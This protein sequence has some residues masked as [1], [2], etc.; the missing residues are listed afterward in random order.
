MLTAALTTILVALMAVMAARRKYRRYLRGNIDISKALGTL[1]TKTAIVDTSLDLV[2]NAT[3]VSSVKATYSMSNWTP[4]AAA[5]PIEL[6]WA[7]GD[8]TL[9]EIEEW[10]ENAGS[11]N[12]GDLIAREQSRRKIRRIGTLPTDNALAAENTEMADGRLV[13]T[14]I[15]FAL[16]EG[17]QLVLVAYNNGGASV[18]TSDPKVKCQGHANL[19]PM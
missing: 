10:I 3:W 11:W 1:A 7:H 5:G 15:G 8:Y 2:V 4:T 16:N 9:A 12:E 19:W 14:K 17:E 6:F 13:T 18:A